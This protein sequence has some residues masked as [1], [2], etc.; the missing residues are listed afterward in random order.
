MAD[1]KIM[2]TNLPFGITE[3]ELI[4]KFSNY[5]LVKKVDIP[6]KL[7]GLTQVQRG[8]AF[9][10][11]PEDADISRIQQSV[12]D[13]HA[14]E[15]RGRKISVKPSKFETRID[16]P[17]KA[18]AVSKKVVKKRKL[19]RKVL[20]TRP[21]IKTDLKV[22]VLGQLQ[23]RKA[24]FDTPIDKKRNGLILFSKTAKE[25]KRNHDDF[26][27][28]KSAENSGIPRLINPTS[29]KE[30]QR[31]IYNSQLKNIVITGDQIP[32]LRVSSTFI[33]GTPHN[34]KPGFKSKIV[35]DAIKGY[36]NFDP[37]EMVKV[38]ANAGDINNLY[39]LDFILKNSVKNPELF[40]LGSVDY[41]NP[42]SIRRLSEVID[43]G[44]KASVVGLSDESVGIMKTQID[45]QINNLIK[46]FKQSGNTG[47]VKL[48]EKLKKDP[49]SLTELELEQIDKVKLFDVAEGAG[50]ATRAGP[51]GMTA[52]SPLGQIATDLFM[53]KD[54]ETLS[55]GKNFDIRAVKDQLDRGLID[56]RDVQRLEEE[57][58]EIAKQKGEFVTDKKPVKDYGIQKRIDPRTGKEILGRGHYR[59]L[60]EIG[61]LPPGTQ[62]PQIF[63]LPGGPAVLKDLVANS[64]DA[65]KVKA[66][67]ELIEKIESNIGKGPNTLPKMA[68][69]GTDLNY[70]SR[71][72][73]LVEDQ[74]TSGFEEGSKRL[75]QLT[76]VLRIA[77]PG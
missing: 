19:V 25:F 31:F 16:M 9:V 7:Q 68:T 33:D 8:Y 49:K 71:L 67:F 46:R 43:L 76:K 26:L 3:K 61:G 41:V 50:F 13:L 44:G 72:I 60:R 20:D 28:V 47:I 32:G 57:A 23:T 29:E 30:I 74:K 37:T 63:K 45:S 40:R 27:L 51:K 55:K 69:L 66:A 73:K 52:R 64:Q 48:L 62:L 77:L 14:T 54:I 12:D 4:E 42:Q 15:I 22:N 11:F 18:Q 24:L 10:S 75:A 2:I 17:D 5:G 21:K 56:T 39:Q 38:K 34:P 36:K 35:D 53:L 1:I 70:A 59:A 65:S 6:K 58:E